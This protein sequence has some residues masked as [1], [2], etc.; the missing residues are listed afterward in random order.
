MGNDT[1]TNLAVYIGVRQ[2]RDALLG[3]MRAMSAELVKGG[4]G[5]PWDGGSDIAF[6]HLRKALAPH[7]GVPGANQ[8]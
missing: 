7:G 5:G 6:D 2:E 4:C 1:E 3:H 8:P